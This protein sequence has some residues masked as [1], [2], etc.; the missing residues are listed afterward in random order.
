MNNQ[1]IGNNNDTFFASKESMIS[2]CPPNKEGFTKN[3]D[4]SREFREYILY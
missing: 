2:E 3:S 1:S 4:V